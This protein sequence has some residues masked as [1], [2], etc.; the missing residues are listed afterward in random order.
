MLPTGFFSH[1]EERIYE[2][3]MDIWS[4]ELRDLG[5]SSLAVSSTSASGI[6]M[7]VMTE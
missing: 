7:R 4:I 2:G 3:C 6:A 5:R 1:S